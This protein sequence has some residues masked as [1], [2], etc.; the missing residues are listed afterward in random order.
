MARPLQFRNQFG[1][2]PPRL[3]VLRL[4]RVLPVHKVRVDLF[5]VPE[6]ER[7]RT[8]YLFEGQGRIA[9]NHAKQIDE[10]IKR[11]PSVSYSKTPSIFRTYSFCIRQPANTWSHGG[12]VRHKRGS[13]Q[14]LKLG[15]SFLGPGSW[16]SDPGV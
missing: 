16:R 15:K 7:Q 13:P 5:L 14:C 10:R 12:A 4:R 1:I 6:L 9:F 11:D 3:P 2:R 8:M